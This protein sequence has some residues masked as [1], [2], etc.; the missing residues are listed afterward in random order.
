M[1]S[2]D[3]V[4]LAV[5][6]LDASADHLLDEHGLTS[7]VGGSHPTWG[8]ANRIVPLGDTY[9]ELIAVQDDAVAVRTRFGSAVAAAAASGTDRWLTWALRDD[10]IEA[11]AARLG[12]PLSIGERAGPDGV[13]VRWRT[14]GVDDPA[15]PQELP[16]FIAWEGPD[17]DHPGR[18]PIVHPSGAEAIARIELGVD[19]RTLD[20]WTDHAE[21]PV[22]LVEGSPGIRAVA[23]RT[24]DGESV[25]E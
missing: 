13:I 5:G 16:F 15:R 7:V 18:T 4:V 23:V 14:A 6:D 9:L 17:S 22:R 24:P 10:G 21:L 25:V 2:V 12:L 11:T 19:R 3:H 8:T 20:R 1:R